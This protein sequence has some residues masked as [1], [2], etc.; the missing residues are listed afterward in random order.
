MQSGKILPWDSSYNLYHKPISPFVAGFI[1]EGRLLQASMEDGCAVHTALGC[2]SGEFT[3]KYKAKEFKGKVLIRPEDVIHDD[4]SQVKARV[5]RRSF[6]GPNI[7]YEL[8]LASE[9]IV[10]ALVPSYCEH[11]VGESIG[12]RS[13]VHH[14][15]LFAE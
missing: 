1:G 10:Q 6:R 2:L 9:E 5:M 3:P 4:T 15:I 11:E 8:Q 7:M 13:D 12:I 14:I